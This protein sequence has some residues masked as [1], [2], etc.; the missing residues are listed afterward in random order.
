[1]PGQAEQS[2]TWE[3]AHLYSKHNQILGLYWGN[4]Q[5]PARP[6]AWLEKFVQKP[7]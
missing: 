5:S 3:T 1:M 2:G 7:F 6:W 4:N